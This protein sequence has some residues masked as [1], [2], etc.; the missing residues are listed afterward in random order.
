MDEIKQK[1]GRGRPPEPFLH[2][3][4][5]GLCSLQC[6]QSEIASF[7]KMAHTTLIY[8]VEKHY[9]MPFAEAYKIYSE[10]G[11][12]SLRRN[13]FAHS[14]KN[15]QIAIH[16]SKIYLDMNYETKIEHSAVPS[17]KAILELPDNGNRYLKNDENL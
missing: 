16:L 4:F 8:K 11:K 1:R 14:K 10:K 2:E 12:C 7:M 13:L 15:A 3:T 9:K 17:Q 6:T 5:E